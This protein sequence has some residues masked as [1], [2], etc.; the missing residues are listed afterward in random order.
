MLSFAAIVLKA[1]EMQNVL[2]AQQGSKGGD[3][4][5]N[6]VVS[7]VIG[8]LLMGSAPFWWHPMLKAVG[9]EPEIP[10]IEGGC[11]DGYTLF[12]QNKWAPA[13]A[14]IRAGPDVGAKKLGSLGGNEPLVVDGWVTGSVPYPNNPAPYDSNI[15]FHMK[16]GAGYVSFGGVRAQPTVF[17]PTSRDTAGQIPAPT[18]LACRA[19]V[20]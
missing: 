16:N 3:R 6:I 11:G 12:A 10:S 8:V 9:Q 5:F 2:V 20:R 18:P 15:W 13:G 19:V 4:L 1:S 14:S 17:D 7:I